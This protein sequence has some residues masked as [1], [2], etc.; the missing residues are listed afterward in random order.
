MV[1]IVYA[2]ASRGSLGGVRRE[3]GYNVYKERCTGQNGYPFCVTTK[4]DM[5]VMPVVRVMVVEGRA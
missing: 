5:M 1:S 2:N 4:R 3:R